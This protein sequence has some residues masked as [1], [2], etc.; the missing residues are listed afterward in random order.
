MNLISISAPYSF[1][2]NSSH[3]PDRMLR[4][5]QSNHM[6]LRQVPLAVCAS[7]EYRDSSIGKSDED[8][9]L[10]VPVN[11]GDALNVRYELSIRSY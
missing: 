7:S 11:N 5:T 1:A 2:A 8:S 9:T 6:I 4:A 3:A 10:H